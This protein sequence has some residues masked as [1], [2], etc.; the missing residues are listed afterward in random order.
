MKVAKT[1]NRWGQLGE[2]IWF[3]LITHIVILAACLARIHSCHIHHGSVFREMNKESSLFHLDTNIE[4][5]FFHYTIL[6]CSDCIL[7]VVTV[8]ENRWIRSSVTPT[9]LQWEKQY[10]GKNSGVLFLKPAC[11]HFQHGRRDFL[12]GSVNLLG[13]TWG[14]VLSYSQKWRLTHDF[15]LTTRISSRGIV[16]LN[17]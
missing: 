9:S 2:E 13:G 10:W 16:P 4:G 6:R 15:Q 11:C 12:W 8:D 17:A 5:D 3:A 1:K 14:V 7:E